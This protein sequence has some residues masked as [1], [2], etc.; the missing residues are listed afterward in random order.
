MLVRTVTDNSKV[1]WTRSVIFMRSSR[2]YWINIPF[3]YAT[4]MKLQKG[5]KMELQTDE[6]GNLVML[7]SKEVT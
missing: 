2:S 4:K 7:K 5:Q 6:L 1:F 3:E